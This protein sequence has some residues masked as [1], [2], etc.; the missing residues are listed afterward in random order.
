MNNWSS[1]SWLII[2]LIVAL[3]LSILLFSYLQGVKRTGSKE[4]DVVVA[5]Q[6][7][8]AGSRLTPDVVKT[9]QMPAAY[10]HP[11]AFSTRQD[12]VN[13]Y[14]TVDLW[15]DEIVISDQ[16]TTQET[17]SDLPF[18]IPEGYRAVTIKIDQVSGV[19]GQVKPGHRVD[20]LMS[21]KPESA[22]TKETQTLT[23]LQNILVLSVGGNSEK[24]KEDNAAST[25][26]L[27]VTPDQAEYVML[28]EN[29]GNIKLS[30]RPTT[31][32]R[33]VPLTKI[34]LNW[35]LSQY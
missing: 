25:M 18:R 6:N 4:V 11:H 16:L 31:D 33:Q 27:A 2:T 28:A 10:R 22:A 13:K 9:V 34:N 8:K 7:I 15:A 21:A 17:S 29:T 5:A 23:L 1:K 19:A 14:T 3:L 24:D 35:L 30:L 26:T 12:V 32:N 20:V